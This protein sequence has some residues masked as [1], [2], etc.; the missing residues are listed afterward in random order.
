MTETVEPK[1]EEQSKT[2]ASGPTIGRETIGGPTP[3]VSSV[4]GDGKPKGDKPQDE[5]NPERK[6]PEFKVPNPDFFNKVFEEA[7]K[8]SQSLSKLL[9]KSTLVAAVLTGFAKKE[10]Q[11]SVDNEPPKATLTVGT[12]GVK[13]FKAEMKN[14]DKSTDFEGN[15]IGAQ[16][17]KE[18]V[19]KVVSEKE[20]D[21]LFEA[22]PIEKSK[23][24]SNV[25]LLREGVTPAK[26]SSDDK[27][28]GM[29]WEVAVATAG[30]A[31]LAAAAMEK[32]KTQRK[33]GKETRGPMTVADMARA[34]NKRTAGR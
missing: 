10:T 20:Q 4:A 29:P 23:Q 11:Q 1:K 31:V 21:L 16:M 13:V 19:G 30:A 17:A 3:R 9:V 26:D 28:S 12:L 7:M 22:N 18:V 8:M 14:G 5:K 6:W 24:K 15:M 25:D 27:K 33:D 34:G 2:A 32:N